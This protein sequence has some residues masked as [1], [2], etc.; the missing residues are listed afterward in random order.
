MSSREVRSNAGHVISIDGGMISTSPNTGGLAP[1]TR[2]DATAPNGLPSTGFTFSLYDVSG[3]AVAAVAP[4]FVVQ[5]WLWNP[6]SQRWTSFASKSSVNYDEL[7][8][9]Y[10]VDGGCALYF[11]ITNFL[12]VGNIGI[13]VCEQ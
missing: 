1:H 9:T 4:G 8:E 12:G 5:I 10:D 6:V 11:S 13:A 2:L 7:Y 3:G